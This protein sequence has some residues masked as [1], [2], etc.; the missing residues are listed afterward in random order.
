MYLMY[1]FIYIWAG[2]VMVS[3]N[4]ISCLFGRFNYSD[5]LLFV[6]LSSSILNIFRKDLL[7]NLLG[8]SCSSLAF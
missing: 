4:L 3:F 7:S 5:I 8:L 2:M 6:T 1:I